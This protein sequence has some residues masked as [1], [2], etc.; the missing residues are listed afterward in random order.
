V[1]QYSSLHLFP[2]FPFTISSAPFLIS[3]TS[4]IFL[5]KYSLFSALRERPRQVV[6]LS[7]PRL[8]PPMFLQVTPFQP[9]TASK[10]GTSGPLLPS[11]CLPPSHRFRIPPK[12]PRFQGRPVPPGFPRGILPFG[13]HN[14][15]PSSVQLRIAQVPYG[16][17]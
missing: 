15:P 1:A 9:L 10:T 14:L 7:S 6:C 2:N 5:P 4:L 11:R 16:F 13:A 3:V 8:P 12:A 17:S